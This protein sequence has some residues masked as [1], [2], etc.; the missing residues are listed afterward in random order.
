MV[1]APTHCFCRELPLAVINNCGIN[2]ILTDQA[3]VREIN[4]FFDSARKSN[5]NG[6]VAGFEKNHSNALATANHSD[7]MRTDSCN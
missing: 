7:A 5:R 2:R 4:S 3:M 6:G 1:Q